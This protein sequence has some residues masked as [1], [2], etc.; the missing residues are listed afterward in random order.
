M[1]RLFFLGSEMRKSVLNSV[2]LTKAHAGRRVAGGV[3]GAA[4]RTAE[5]NWQNEWKNYYFKRK[6]K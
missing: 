4:A 5:C 2:R 6:K 1:Q 3:G